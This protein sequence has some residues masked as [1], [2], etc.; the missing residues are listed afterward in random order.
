M[1]H[2][3]YKIKIL[4]HTVIEDLLVKK[5]IDVF[6]TKTQGIPRVANITTENIINISI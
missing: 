3:I 6:K 4:D 5:R 2:E 1:K